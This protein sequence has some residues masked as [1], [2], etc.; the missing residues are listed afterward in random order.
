MNQQLQ[1]GGQRESVVQGPEQH[2][3]RASRKQRPN[4]IAVIRIQKVIR[5]NRKKQKN[6]CRKGGVNGNSPEPGHDSR[7]HLALIRHV[8]RAYLECQFSYERRQRER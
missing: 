6:A 3:Q 5:Q 4:Q 7:M 1:L 2:D 8:H